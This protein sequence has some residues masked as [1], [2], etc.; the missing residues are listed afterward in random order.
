MMKPALL[1]RASLLRMARN[2]SSVMARN[3]SSASKPGFFELRT[4]YV[5]PKKLDSYLKEQKS[6]AA[7]R[8]RVFP[9]WLG[10][11]RTELGGACHQ[12]H[13]LYH[14]ENYDQR[15]EARFGADDEYEF[16]GKTLCAKWDQPALSLHP[17][18]LGLTRGRRR[19]PC[20]Q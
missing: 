9:G 14:W 5:K 6:T 16:Y 17:K 20:S 1:G 10:I 13:H 11:W 4:D 19:N 18:D 15:D 7:T 3:F 8:K 12:I 2:F